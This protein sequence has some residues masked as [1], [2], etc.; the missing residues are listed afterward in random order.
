MR[1]IAQNPATEWIDDVGEYHE[2][3]ERHAALSWIKSLGGPPVACRTPLTP[4]NP[5]I[6]WIGNEPHIPSAGTGDGK[7]RDGDERHLVSSEQLRMLERSNSRWRAVEKVE[8]W[9]G[10][11]STITEEF[12][13][14]THRHCTDSE[15]ERGGNIE[16]R[17]NVS[18]QSPHDSKTRNTKAV[19]TKTNP[20]TEWMRASEAGLRMLYT[21]TTPT[22]PLPSRQRKRPI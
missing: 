22:R 9:L 6:E 10:R 16:A 14:R 12:S 11:T 4:Q 3:H 1:F 13:S 19:Y 21:R 15:D 20:E 2:I 17:H 18:A 8:E 7:E 5:G